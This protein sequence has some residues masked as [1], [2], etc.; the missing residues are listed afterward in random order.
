MPKLKSSKKRLKQERVR[1][2]RNSIVKSTMRRAIKKVRENT[3]AETTPSLLNLALSKLDKAAKRGLIH[4]RT[5]S[6]Q[7]SRLMK[8]TKYS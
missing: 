6:R 8:A 2:A 3:D 5:A 1:Q 4:K 7:K